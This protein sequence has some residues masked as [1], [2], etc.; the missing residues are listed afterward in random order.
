MYWPI[1][2]AVLKGVA[3]GGKAVIAVGK[4]AKTVG[5][6][7]GGAVLKTGKAMSVGKAKTVSGFAKG[8]G[9]E[10]VGAKTEKGGG[11][12]VKA[13][14][15]TVK[16]SK[17][18][19]GGKSTPPP[20]MKEDVLEAPKGRQQTLWTKNI[21]TNP[22][23]YGTH[24]ETKGSIK[25][26]KRGDKPIKKNKAKSKSKK[27]SKTISKPKRKE[28]V[29]PDRPLVPGEGQF[30]VDPSILGQFNTGGQ[31]AEGGGGPFMQRP[32][33]D[34][35]PPPGDVQEPLWS[36][37]VS[38]TARL[39]TMG[40]KPGVRDFVERYIP[41]TK[42]E[43]EQEKVEEARDLIWKYIIPKVDTRQEI[44]EFTANPTFV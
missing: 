15:E 12:T 42:Y 14:R 24:K 29:A 25:A 28:S 31:V 8:V 36:K 6:T 33:E 38:G 30:D 35:S 11:K 1:V 7:Y 5:S 40:A 21:G 32:G 16:I 17:S 37:A 34:E 18:L 44:K 22:V 43:Q 26:G 3:T 39:L 9:R 2:T 20:P 13:G 10:L 27:T 41:S 4:T 19:G 23:H